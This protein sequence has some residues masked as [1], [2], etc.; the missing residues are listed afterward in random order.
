MYVQQVVLD[1]QSVKL[2]V[3]EVYNVCIAGSTGCEEFRSG[4][5]GG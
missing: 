4:S 2:V 3:Q 1:V 5:T